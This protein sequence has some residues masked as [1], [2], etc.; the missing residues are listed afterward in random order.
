MANK[1][2]TPVVTKRDKLPRKN[3]FKISAGVQTGTRIKNVDNSG[4]KE[5]EVIGVIGCRGIMNRLPRASVSDIV[6]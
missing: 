3:R 4:V 5:V 6:V 1:A 2:A